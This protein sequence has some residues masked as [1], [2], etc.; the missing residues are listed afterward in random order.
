MQLQSQKQKKKNNNRQ[1]NKIQDDT[2]QLKTNKE[3]TLDR[4]FGNNSGLE[5]VVF[6]R[7]VQRD[8]FKPP[9]AT[10]PTWTK[11]SSDE[12]PTNAAR[13]TTVFAI[14]QETYIFTKAKARDAEHSRQNSCESAK[15]CALRKINK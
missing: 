15:Q 2:R 1:T 5:A 3:S 10:T 11:Q 7:P 4:Q 6:S 9:L 13:K 14:A 12:S 8:V